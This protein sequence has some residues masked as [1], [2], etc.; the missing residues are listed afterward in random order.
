MKID[1]KDYLK[2]RDRLLGHK[3]VESGPVITISRQLGCKANHIA[4]KLINLITNYTNKHPKA[5][6]WTYINKEIIKDS[7]KELNISEE[8][9]ELKIT[10][11]K[12][13]GI[14]DLLSAFETQYIP[15]KELITKVKEVIN[16]YAA[17]GQVI[18]VGRGGTALT[19]ELDNRIHVKLR[20]PRAWRA[21][22]IANEK[23]CTLEEALSI[24]DKIDDK[25]IK[26]SEAVS[27]RTYD[28][29]LFDLIFNCQRLSE[30]EIANAIFD[31]MVSSGFVK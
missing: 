11:N 24:V 10:Q 8:L 27:G 23:G 16:V 1:P 19:Q 18:I 30:Q 13:G 28:D 2:E 9:L 25:R 5:N 29:D 15:N 7:S 17:K 4:I 12:H 21:E 6:K 3:K 14:S 26:W 20:A 31:L 22:K